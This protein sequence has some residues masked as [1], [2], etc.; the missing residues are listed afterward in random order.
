MSWLEAG[1]NLPPGVSPGDPHIVGWPE[2]ELP[3]RC[4]GC[5]REVSQLSADGGCPHCGE[6]LVPELEP[7]EGW[8]R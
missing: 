3:E 1:F 5:G 2:E 7:D 6:Q 4:P 8:D